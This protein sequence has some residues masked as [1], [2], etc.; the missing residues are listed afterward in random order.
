MNLMTNKVYSKI[1][2]IAVELLRLLRK[3]FLMASLQK[4]ERVLE[5]L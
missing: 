5:H 2:T 1:E 4:C 3:M